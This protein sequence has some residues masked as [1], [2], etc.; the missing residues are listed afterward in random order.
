[1]NRSLG[2]F[3]IV[4]LICSFAFAE[5]GFYVEQQTH[6]PAVMGQPAKDEVAK[7]W[8]SDTGYRIESGNT[9]MI[10]RFDTNII[11]NID[12]EKKSYFETD[13]ETMKEMANM[14]K[15]MMGNAGPSTFEFKKTGNNKKIKNWNC[16]EVTAK[17]AMMKHTMWL[18]EDLP[19]GKDTYHKF[20]KNIPEFEELA[21]SIYNSEELKGYPVANEMEM[22]IMGMQIK[23][24]SELISIEEKDIPSGTFNLPTGLEKVDNPMKNMRRPGAPKF[25]Q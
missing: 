8:I 1:M 9:I 24:S 2:I 17:N 7:T 22:N 19:Y 18:T 21:E 23:S 16:Y 20:Y 3:I 5:K 6:T 4:L 12:L 11:W 10:L 14:G 13:A 15:A 25:N